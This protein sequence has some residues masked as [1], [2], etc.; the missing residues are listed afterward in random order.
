M[1]TFVETENCI[2]CKHTDCVDVCP[3]DAFREGEN[4]LVISPD[5]CI[6]CSM[7]VPE[8]PVDAIYADAEIPADQ[9]SFLALNR[10]L[11]ESWTLITTKKPAPD[12][13]HEWA[14]VKNKLEHLIR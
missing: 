11:A 13:A 6:D 8:C 14:G 12:D 2:R 3:A 5:D 1:M 9:Q 4:F 10:E 7:C